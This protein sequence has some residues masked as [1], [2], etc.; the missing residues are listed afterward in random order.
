MPPALALGTRRNIWWCD[1]LASFNRA[2]EEETTEANTQSIDDSLMKPSFKTKH[3]PSGDG[4]KHSITDAEKTE[5]FPSVCP[6]FCYQREL[7]ASSWTAADE[8]SKQSSY[9]PVPDGK[10]EINDRS[11]DSHMD[12]QANQH[13][14]QDTCELHREDLI[15]L[16]QPTCWKPI[17]LEMF[18]IENSLVLGTHLL[19]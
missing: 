7:K 18:Q 12:E 19:G 17:R 16:T 9:K 2:T 3:D 11:G 15:D 10:G 5:L 6:C 13:A 1:N 4:E 8:S 14:Y